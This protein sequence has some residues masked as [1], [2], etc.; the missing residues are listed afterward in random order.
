M[1]SYRQPPYVKG[2]TNNKGVPKNRI[3][4]S[5]KPN[6]GCPTKNQTDG[7]GNRIVSDGV[8]F[9]IGQRS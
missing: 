3:S 7:I 6:V 8:S 5:G 9:K 1:P 2:I 4:T